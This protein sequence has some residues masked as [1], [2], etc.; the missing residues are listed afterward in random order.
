MTTER[1]LLM[2]FMR[3][4]VRIAVPY[5]C[6][7]ASIVVMGYQ[8]SLPLS[9]GNSLSAITHLA[10]FAVII[11]ANPRV[12][13]RVRNRFAKACLRGVFALGMCMAMFFPFYVCGVAV[14]FSLGLA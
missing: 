12:F 2:E 9:V 14:I 1:G 6:V 4:N 5:W 7:C 13:S 10:L 3:R 8:L 11:M